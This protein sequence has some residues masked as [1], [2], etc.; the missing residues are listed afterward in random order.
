MF[1]ALKL[2]GLQSHLFFGRKDVIANRL[3]A[4]AKQVCG[5]CQVDYVAG[6]FDG[7]PFVIDPNDR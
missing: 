2:V 6:N 3:V 1:E 7:P 4:V 5:L